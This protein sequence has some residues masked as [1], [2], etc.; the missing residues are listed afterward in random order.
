MD[1]K[2]IT[3]LILFIFFT[4]NAFGNI[5]YNK[6]E[7]IITDIE[8]N[9]YKELYLKNYN[10]KINDS[11]GLKDLVLINN[12]INFL[13]KNN[14]EFVNKI[15]KSI[16]DQFGKKIQDNE[17]LLNFYRFSKI[18]D[19]FIY[20]Y[21]KNDLTVNEVQKV[22]KKFDN[23][24]LPISDNECLIIKDIIETKENRE[25]VYNFFDNLKNNTKNYR[26]K[27]DGIIYDVCIDNKNYY[28]IEKAIVSYI[29]EQTKKEFEYF[30]YEK[31]KN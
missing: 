13:K 27:I 24:K 4:L 10:I 11:N 29:R 25:F 20:E 1:Y 5:I 15:D 28:K 16:V 19:E 22:F 7:I 14:S 6:N 26:L 23:L 21:F 30:V 2:F 31:I 18:R 9:L 8:L 12:V 3:K 17:I